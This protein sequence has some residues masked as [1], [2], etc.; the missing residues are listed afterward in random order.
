MSDKDRLTILEARM[1]AVEGILHQILEVLEQEKYPADQHLIPLDKVLEIVEER[2]AE[3]REQWM[4]T[5][6][7]PYEKPLGMMEA[8]NIL[9]H[10]EQEFGGDTDDEI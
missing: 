5:P 10:L 8:E 1:D 4:G 6:G 7:P 2:V 9:R 3:Y